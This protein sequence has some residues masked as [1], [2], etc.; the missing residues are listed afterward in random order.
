MRDTYQP[1]FADQYGRV[2]ENKQVL[3]R[4]YAVHAVRIAKNESEAL[5]LLRDPG[6]TP[7]KEVILE[8]ADAPI[9]LSQD[10]ATSDAQIVDYS[11]MRVTVHASM[12]ADGYLVLS[13]TYYPGWKCEVDGVAAP[14]YQANYLFRAVYLP[15]GE[16]RITFTYEPVALWTGSAIS[17][18]AFTVTCAMIIGLAVRRHR[19]ARVEHKCTQQ[20]FKDPTR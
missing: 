5:Q 9:P 10:T 18:S 6:F 17:L 7:A 1:A 19:W 8:D 13:D 14:I 2:Y 3:P 16:H 15:S 4:A 20:H 11:P 12:R